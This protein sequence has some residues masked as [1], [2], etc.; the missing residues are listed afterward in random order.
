[1]KNQMIV[2]VLCLTFASPLFAQKKEEQRIA[3]SATV[4]QQLLA[5]DRACPLMSLTRPTVLS[6]FP[7]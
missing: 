6:S 7:A 5:G 1:M 3:N 2:F 4:L